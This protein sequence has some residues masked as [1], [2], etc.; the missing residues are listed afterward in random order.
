CNRPR[1]RGVAHEAL[2]EAVERW[3]ADILACA[4]LSVRAIKAMVR[5]GAGLSARQAQMLRLPQLVEALQSEDQDGGVRAF[6]EKRPP[7]WTGR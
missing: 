7:V 2:D 3:V 1:Q 4:P 6:R 5:A